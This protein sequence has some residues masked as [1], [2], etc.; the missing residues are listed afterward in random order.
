MKARREEKRRGRINKDK[1]KQQ[2]DMKIKSYKLKEKEARRIY[3]EKIQ[4]QVEETRG[5]I[6]KS[7]LEECWQ[8]FKGILMKSAE[9]CGKRVCNQRIK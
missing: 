9:A 5:K 7:D 4:Q 1:M 6:N 3:Q 8:H 2:Q